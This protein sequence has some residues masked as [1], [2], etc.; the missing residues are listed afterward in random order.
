MKN[1]LLIL[2]LFFFY[3]TSHPQKTQKVNFTI[4]SVV[5]QNPNTSTPLTCYVDF[6]TDLEYQHVVFTLTGN[7]HSFKL[8]YTP[9]DKKELGY[10]MML[11]KPETQYQIGIKITDKQGNL[12]LSANTQTFKTP[13]LP[14]DPAQFPG[15]EITKIS[16]NKMEKGLT[17]FNPRRRTPRN[18]AGSNQFEK[19]F[20]MLAMVDSQGNV[21]W[22]YKTN[23]R[24]SDCDF[25]SNGN[26]S[27]MTQDSRIVE[28]DLAGNI[29]KEW[30]ATKRPDGKHDTATPVKAL[31]FHHDAAFL[32]N[33]N[34]LALSS[35]IKEIDGYYTSEVDSLAP[36]EKQ[37]VMG[38][39][40]IE[41]TPDGEIV[42]RWKAFENMPVFRIGYET[43][44]GYWERRGFPGVIDWSHAN[45]VVPLPDENAYLVN[46]RYQ[47]A[48]IK[49]DKTTGE[50][51]WIFAEP[52]GWGSNL[53]GKL[54]KLRSEDWCWHQHSPS[55][56]SSGSLLFF[57][58]NNY[59]ARPFNKPVKRVESNSHVVE[60]RINEKD[61]S[62]EKLWTSIIPGEIPVAST[63]MGSA[64]ELPETGNILAGYGL[65]ISNVPGI[66]NPGNRVWTMVRE[67]THDTPAEIVWE[68]RLV[69]LNKESKVGWTLFGANRV[70]VPHY[71][72]LK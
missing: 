20:G 31:T 19:S 51:R 70:I 40:V 56:T 68:I 16:E 59:Q 53:K 9:A 43:F 66:T 49:I 14:K 2:P 1:Y 52:S 67:F 15:I 10:L 46:F 12:T 64:V 37:K 25:L 26:I 36:C 4:P 18:T 39:V 60:Y 28:I 57:N 71:Q 47:S 30:Y 5:V 44:S 41:F 63:A 69:P 11:M 13:P 23:S 17:L 33:G 38:D 62:V 50:I 7:E 27:Y 61:M 55:F 58:N 24:I 45:A 3:L 72:E 65:L 21:L 35:E 42:H 34:V 22:Y 6:E 48:M 29:Q 8:A 32:P 54:L